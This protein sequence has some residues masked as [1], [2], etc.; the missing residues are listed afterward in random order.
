M[1]QW[2]WPW[3]PECSLGRFPGR[4]ASRLRQQRGVRPL[5]RVEGGRGCS[6]QREHRAQVWSGTQTVIGT[7]SVMGWTEGDTVQ[8]GFNW[9]FRCNR[10]GTGNPCP[11]V[12][13]CGEG[14]WKRSTRQAVPE[15]PQ[16]AR[17]SS[18]AG[19]MN[20]QDRPTLLLRGI[21]PAKCDKES[22]N[23]KLGPHGST[24]TSAEN[25]P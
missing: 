2:H 8:P 15:Q 13:H 14:L 11:T 6:R 21:I 10:I 22:E 18:R 25:G 17:R 4:A 23:R 12:L 24:E 7:G 20:R 1:P 16:C 3:K 5:G 19:D 9:E